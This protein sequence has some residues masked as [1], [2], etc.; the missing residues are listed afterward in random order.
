[1]LL[2]IAADENNLENGKP[3]EYEIK[4]SIILCNHCKNLN[5]ENK[6]IWWWKL[7]ADFQ[8][9]D[10]NRDKCE[11][12]KFTQWKRFVRKVSNCWVYYLP[13]HISA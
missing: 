11:I 4:C 3:Y 13:D 1:M 7:T 5:K 10:E 6:T 9:F 12:N 8:V 2:T